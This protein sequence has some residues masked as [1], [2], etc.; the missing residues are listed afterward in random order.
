MKLERFLGYPETSPETRK[1]YTKLFALCYI[2]NAVFMIVFYTITYFKWKSYFADKFFIT[3]PIEQYCQQHM[4]YIIV[5]IAS[6]ILAITCSFRAMP[7]LKSKLLVGVVNP[8]VMFN[9]I[10]I[11]THISSIMELKKY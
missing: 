1:Y 5:A 8:L 4:S 10:Q 7:T 6:I 2:V 3:A 11:L 9:V